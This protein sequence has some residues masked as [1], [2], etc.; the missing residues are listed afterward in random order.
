[1]VPVVLGGGTPY[2]PPGGTATL[3]LLEQRV[4]PGG[5]VHLRYARA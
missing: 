1:V 4:F 5:T 2:L 3:R